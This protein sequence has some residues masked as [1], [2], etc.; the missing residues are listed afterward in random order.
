MP[1]ERV[2]ILGGGAGALASAYALTKVPGWQDRYEITVYQN[3]WRLG[4]KGASSRRQFNG[5]WR[6]EEHGPHIW[7]GFYFNAFRMIAEAYE[8]CA[9]HNLT[10]ES[11]FKSWTDAFQA[12]R[13]GTFMEYVAGKWRPWLITMPDRPGSPLQPGDT[14]L[15]THVQD[16][17]ALLLRWFEELEGL[18]PEAKPS[19][20]S[21]PLAHGLD[22]A[23]EWMAGRLGHSLPPLEN[24]DSLLY[25][26]HRLA[27]APHLDPRSRPQGIAS[28]FAR[29]GDWLM[30]YLLRQFRERIHKDIQHL[31]DEHDDIR[32]L[33]E[34]L[35]L[36][37]TTIYGLL[38]DDVLF[39]GFDAIEDVD[40]SH[41]L[42]KHG[43]SAYWS[44]PVHGIYDSGAHYEKGK[45]APADRPNERPASA[46]L[47]A[48]TA[49]SALLRMFAGYSGA[50]SY[51]MQ[52]GMGETVFTPLYLALA[53]Q[54]VKFSFFHQTV[55]LGL[56]PDQAEVTSIEME[57]QATV[58][59]GPEAYRPL[60]D[61]IAGLR[62]WPVE[63]FYD[64]LEE[65]EALRSVDFEAAT[66]SGQR[67][68]TRI[69]K[70]G[71]DFDKVVLGISIAALPA[72]TAALVP[73]PRWKRMLEGVQTVQTQ[74][75]Q[76]WVTRT[77]QQLCGGDGEPV[78]EA[79]AEPY[80]TWLDMSQV[81]ARECWPDSV[82]AQS[83]H[84]F[85]GPLEEVGPVSPPA[86]EEAERAKQQALRFLRSSGLGLWP[87][88]C[89][90]SNRSEFDW[91][92]LVAPATVLGE[93]RFDSQY[94]RA[95]VQPTERYVLSTAGSKFCRLRSDDSGFANLYLAGDW[96]RNGLN[97]GSVEAAVMSGIQAAQ[98]VSGCQI[99][100]LGGYEEMR[101][102]GMA[103]SG[104]RSLAGKGSQL[105]A[106]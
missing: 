47:A 20:H 33:W 22:R 5:G 76:L 86:E 67:G 38:A 28:W 85:V 66:I 102:R 64:Q 24:R 81:L 2:A 48:G 3:G 69:L 103:A 59:S 95:N 26:A 4:G 98:G 90:P 50:F 57:I 94:W 93:E 36:G 31:L 30:R 42:Q 49:V 104:E 68:K 60:L 100:I 77:S 56:S 55:R 27:R 19:K 88:A 29:L 53:D 91:S 80:S 92:V 58:K 78:V 34:L 45:A 52:S 9:Q 75:F 44:P 10:P 99:E 83:V 8:Y 46:N 87:N 23:Y 21:R 79:F 6:I 18:A 17:I 43:S 84:Y 105:A 89:S 54:G 25:R 39:K 7:F 72:I 14:E 37:V 70:R 82:G 41:W 74:F 97:A 65:G 15:W 13:D 96:T 73:V 11:P 1:K 16:G 32:R 35:D 12:K 101:P 62:C 51:K 106:I 61:P 71:E 40:Y 63:P